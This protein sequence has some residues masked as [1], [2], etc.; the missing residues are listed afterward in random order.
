MFFWN[1]LAFLMIQR[2][3]A[4]W[5]LVTK[6]NYV[7][8]S[9]DNIMMLIIGILETQIVMC[10]KWIHTHDW[11]ALKKLYLYFSIY[12][13]LEPFCLSLFFST[14]YPL[15]PIPDILTPEIPRGLTF[16]YFSYF[17]LFFIFKI[18]IMMVYNAIC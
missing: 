3:L 4:I 12:N 9:L 15:F 17:L 8:G 6:S 10:S 13:I 2:I 5:S 1:S 18:A 11:I 14:W 7:R 16:P